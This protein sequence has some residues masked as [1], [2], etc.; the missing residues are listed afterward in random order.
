MDINFNRTRQ[1]PNMKMMADCVPTPTVRQ[2]FI[3]TA[4]ESVA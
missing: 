2:T 4:Q 3:Q 1:T